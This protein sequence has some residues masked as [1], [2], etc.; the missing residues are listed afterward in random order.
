MVLRLGTIAGRGSGRNGNGSGGGGQAE[1]HRCRR[2][3]RAGPGGDPL[4]GGWRQLGGRGRTRSGP[5]GRDHALAP[6]RFA[7]M[8]AA[9]LGPGADRGR[10]VGS[11]WGR[12]AGRCPRHG[13][14]LRRLHP[15]D[16]GV[17]RGGGDLARGACARPLPDPAAARAPALCQLCRRAPLGRSDEFRRDQ[18]VGAAGTAR[19]PGRAGRDARGRTPDADP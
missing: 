6:V 5:G 14:L 3:D 10:R 16:H 12:G 18:P 2:D 4:S 8:G 7:R 19:G 1:G 11:R 15:A 13:C 9:G 17:A